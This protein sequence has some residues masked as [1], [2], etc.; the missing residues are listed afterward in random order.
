[1][2]LYQHDQ[3]KAFRFV[4]VGALDG[5]SALELQSAWETARSVL[6]GRELLVDLTGMTT[7]GPEGLS[8]LSRMQEAGARLLE[9]QVAENGRGRLSLRGLLRCGSLNDSPPGAAEA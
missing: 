8:L 7:A 3:A 2:T 1:M 9:T 6:R 5:A 4:L